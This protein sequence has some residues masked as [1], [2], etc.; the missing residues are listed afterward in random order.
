[1]VTF[2]D[3]DLFYGKVNVGHRLCVEKGKT[4]DLCEAIVTYDIQS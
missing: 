4:V 2:V 3:H 1:M